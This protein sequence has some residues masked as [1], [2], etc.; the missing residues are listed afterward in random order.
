MRYRLTRDL[1]EPGRA[2]LA[3]FVFDD[4]ATGIYGISEDNARRW[5]ATGWLEELAPPPDP[6]VEHGWTHGDSRSG[7][8]LASAQ[9][10]RPARRR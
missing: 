9:S 5:L 10:A 4:E 8:T 3:G 7:D 1:Y 2:L 6:P